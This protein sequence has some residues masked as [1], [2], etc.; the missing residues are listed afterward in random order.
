M[1]L[2]LKLIILKKM[3]I[4]CTNN[5]DPPRKNHTQEQ[6]HVWVGPWIHSKW[7]M[8][9]IDIYR[10]LS[11]RRNRESKQKLTKYGRVQ[12]LYSEY[13]YAY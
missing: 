2:N 12:S 13:L 10:S 7:S 11:Y 3:G 1:Y 5:N 6:L 9:L 4:L 8:K